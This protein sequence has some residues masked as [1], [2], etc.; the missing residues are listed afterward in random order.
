LSLQ[1]PNDSNGQ[2]TKGAAFLLASYPTSGPEQY[3]IPVMHS[4]LT[5]RRCML[6]NNSVVPTNGLGGAI[7]VREA[8]SFNDEYFANTSSTVKI[9]D[10]A[11]GNNVAASGGAVY[12]GA[13]A[14]LTM[15]DSA[16]DGNTASDKGGA[17]AASGV[18]VTTTLARVNFTANTVGGAGAALWMDGQSS[19]G[20]LVMT[21]CT[22]MQ[23]SATGMAA[24]GGAIST[25]SL[26]AVRLHGCSFVGNTVVTE[27]NED[28]CLPALGTGSGGALY[29][30]DSMAEMHL[31]ASSCMFA[32]NSATAGGAIALQAG[33]TAALFGTILAH[34][35]ATTSGGALR[36]DSATSGDMALINCTLL[37]NE[38]PNGGAVAM[39][40]MH[41]LSLTASNVSYNTA[42]Y[43]AVVFL[44]ASV[45]DAGSQLVLASLAA[46]NNTAAASGGLLFAQG[47]S[48]VVAG[49]DGGTVLLLTCDTCD[50]RGTTAGSYG[51]LMASPPLRFEAHCASATRSAAQLPVSVV[52][53]DAFGTVVRDWP[54]LVAT[55]VCLDAISG[56]PAPA[57]LSGGTLALYARGSAFFPYIAIT[58]AI[59]D[60]FKLALTL[61]SPG[62]I[63]FA[64]G[65]TVHVNVTVAPCD[66]SERFDA[67]ASRCG[68]AENSIRLSPNATSCVCMP[69]FF[70]RRAAL[71]ACT[72]CPAGAR[73]AD[74][75]ALTDSGFWRRGADD[76]RA[77]ECGAGRC[78]AVQPPTLPA[79]G[80]ADQ[81]R[82]RLRQS[83][84]ADTPAPPNTAVSGSNC[85]PGHAGPLCAV[86]CAPGLAGCADGLVY[87]FEGDTCVACS[88]GDLWAGWSRWRQSVLLFFVALLALC[89]LFV[90]L[91]LPLFPKV[92]ACFADA[93]TLLVTRLHRAYRALP[94][95]PPPYKGP[96]LH[97][98]S[99]ALQRNWRRAGL[100]HVGHVGGAAAS[101]D[102]RIAVRDVSSSAPKETPA[103]EPD[104]SPQSHQLA[105]LGDAGLDGVPSDERGEHE[106]H[107]NKTFA[108]LKEKLEELSRPAKIVV[109]VLIMPR[110]H[111]KEA[112]VGAMRYRGVQLIM[113]AFPPSNCVAAAWSAGQFPAD[114]HVLSLHA[115]RDLAARFLRHLSAAVRSERATFGAAQPGMHQ[116]S[117]ILLQDLPRI[118]ARLLRCRGARGR[119]VRCR[120][121]GA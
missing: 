19:S 82:R 49:A 119:R 3:E 48:L 61:T 27:V 47:A 80:G 97:V 85:T 25:E 87:A 100:A 106:R 56:L 76:M 23:N 74:G 39:S 14:S 30:A 101:D 64:A 73:C 105:A 16:L 108:Q 59:G 114:H 115:T 90:G 112:P 36:L 41:T 78:R 1:G 118:H 81:A 55:A 95:A 18:A 120:R 107:H 62:L 89:V 109:R 44:D 24:H 72:A 12:L 32:N 10:S 66:A 121:R 93:M 102:D 98:A 94:C 111:D 42:V 83:M 68:C 104:N 88:A 63:A 20:M 79:E 28:Q 35:V 46:T 117:A 13:G 84:L 31:S 91:M 110:L 116:P 15:E 37:A 2:I 29:A 5:L 71:G 38:A 69:G 99:R 45:A 92:S 60:T 40:G 75:V 86:C 96:E 103:S 43:G 22:F 4:S 6:A 7:H 11:L 58:G 26:A 113:I 65:M 52:A 77:Y 8:N 51:D 53:Y 9:L 50:T 54:A 17:M 67:A 21:A 70:W 57:A 34:N 33:V